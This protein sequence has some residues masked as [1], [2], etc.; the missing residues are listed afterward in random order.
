MKIDKDLRDAAAHAGELAL[1]AAAVLAVLPPEKQKALDEATSG[2]L[3]DSLAKAIWAAAKISPEFAQS[4]HT[5]PP[6]M[7]FVERT[8]GQGRDPASVERQR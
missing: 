4:L 2:E 5:H 7:D 3:G 1:R 6:S 8:G